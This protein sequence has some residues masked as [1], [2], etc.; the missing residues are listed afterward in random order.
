MKHVPYQVPTNI[1]RH[2][3]QFSGPDGLALGIFAPL[4]CEMCRHTY[5]VLG[6]DPVHSVRHTSYTVND[7][8]RRILQEMEHV[9]W[10]GLHIM[11]TFSVH[12]VPRTHKYFKDATGRINSQL[13]ILKFTNLVQLL[14]ICIEFFNP[15]CPLLRKSRV[16]Y[17]SEEFRNFTS[18]ICEVLNH[19]KQ[20]TRKKSSRLRHSLVGMQ[21]YYTSLDLQ[22]FTVD[23][24]S[25]PYTGSQ[26]RWSDK[27]LDRQW[28]SQNLGRHKRMALACSYY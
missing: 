5:C 3:S 7:K 2:Y 26:G 14:L 19:C 28:L 16:L 11:R 15:T 23:V 1:R 20:H 13:G 12:F 10:H 27:V 9:D 18:A 4:E 8:N 17:S 6:N 24:R 22:S 21:I 25:S